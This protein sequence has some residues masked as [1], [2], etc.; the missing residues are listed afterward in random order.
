MTATTAIKIGPADNGRRM[1]LADFEHAEVEGGYL[2]ELGRGVVVV[3]D[4]PNPPH[5]AQVDAVRDQLVYYKVTHAGKIHMLLS[6]SE[7]K[8]LVADQE[9]ER[10]P[11]LAVYMTLPP[12]TD[13]EVWHTW[14]PEIIIEVVS[15]DSRQRDYQE[16]REEYLAFGVKE[17]WIFNIDREE[18]LV[19][20]RRAGRWAERSVR[21]PEVYRTRLLPGL[22]FSCAAVFEAGRAAGA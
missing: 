17:Y 22:E 10:H 7:C 8:V 21:P 14:V 3:S 6:G 20:Q 15:A 11:D 5:A 19:L 9:S 1:S 4:V 16:K 18:M 2:Y 13:S 12:G